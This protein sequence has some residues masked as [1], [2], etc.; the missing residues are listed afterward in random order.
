MKTRQATREF[1]VVFVT[2]KSAREAQRIAS[3]LVKQKLAACVNIVGPVKA[4][5]RWKGRIETAS[6]T[7][8]VIKSTRRKFGALEKEIRRVHSYDTPEI[9]ALPVAAGSK[10]Y[11]EWLRDCM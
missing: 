5:Y 11:L 8:M 1:V 7:L 10:P 9:I 4:I 2:C 6:E 3:R